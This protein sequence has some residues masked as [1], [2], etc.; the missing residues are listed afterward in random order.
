MER[1]LAIGSHIDD[2][3]IGCGGTLIKHKMKGDVI[4]IAVLIA[5]TTTGG[6]PALRRKEQMEVAKELGVDLTMVSGKESITNLVCMLDKIQ[7]TRIYFPFETDHH[8]DHYR[9]FQTAFAVGRKPSVNLM[10]YLVT[11]SYGYYPNYFSIID[12]DR[13]KE[14]VSIFKTQT[15]RKSRYIDMFVNQNRFFGT[16]VDEDGVYAEGFVQYKNVWR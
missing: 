6:D 7:A 16:L 14:L 2:V 11:T 4:H 5:D 15:E 12:I 13:K 8:Q 1:V 10:G 3:E 9:A